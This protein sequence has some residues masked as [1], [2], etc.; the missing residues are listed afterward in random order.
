MKSKAHHVVVFGATSFAGQIL[1]RY[2]LEEF[3]T[4]GPLQWT[5][6]G[7]SAEAFSR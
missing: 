7:R 6:A 1:V 2:L 5:I 4:D 3:G